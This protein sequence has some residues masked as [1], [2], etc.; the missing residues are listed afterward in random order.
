MNKL[1]TIVVI[2]I[3]LVSSFACGNAANTRPVMHGG[4][5][6]DISEPISEPETTEEAAETPAPKAGIIKTSLSLPSVE[7]IDCGEVEVFVAGSDESLGEVSLKEAREYIAHLAA[8][9]YETEVAIDPACGLHPDDL[10]VQ[11]ASR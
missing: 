3:A 9:G 5:E 2:A 4:M 11:V 8:I 7:H 1:N 10:I 6:I